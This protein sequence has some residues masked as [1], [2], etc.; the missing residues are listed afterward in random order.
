METQTLNQTPNQTAL[1]AAVEQYSERIGIGFRPDARF[2]SK[3]GINRKRYAQLYRAEKRPTID[4][5]RAL[6]TFFSVS[7]EQLF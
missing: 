1:Q 2:Y 4:E 3:V 7:I 6:A 5:A